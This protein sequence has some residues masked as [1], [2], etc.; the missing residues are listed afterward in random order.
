MKTRDSV[1]REY[2][3]IEDA[4]S[5]GIVPFD[6]LHNTQGAYQTLCWVLNC[7]RA[8][9]PSKVFLAPKKKTRAKS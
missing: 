1:V 9:A 2:R 5:K 7:D 3:K 8:M 6:N 4:L